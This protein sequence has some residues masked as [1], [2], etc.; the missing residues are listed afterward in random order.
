VGSGEPG[1]LGIRR[2]AGSVPA[3]LLGDLAQ[4]GVALWCILPDSERAA[5]LHSDLQQVLR[6]DSSVLFLPPTD[7]RPY[8]P[9]H[10]DDPAPVIQRADVFQRLADGWRGVLVTGADALL[11]KVPALRDVTSATLTVSVGPSPGP[12][13]LLARL[14]ELGFARVEFVEQPGE[15]ALRGGILDVFPFVGDFP[16]RLEFFGDDIDSIREF[17]IHTQRSVSRR[18]SARLVPNLDRDSAADSARRVSLA[19]CLSDDIVVALFDPDS[20]TAELR[21]RFERISEAFEARRATGSDVRPPGDWYLH[22]EALEAGIAARRRLVLGGVGAPAAEREIDFAC[23]P[24]PS[25]NRAMAPLR[26]QLAVNARN[27]LRTV[28]LCDSRGQENRLRQLLEDEIEPLGVL[29]TVESLHEGFEAPGLGLAV[30]TDHQIFERY[31]RP[32]ARRQKQRFGGLSLRELHQLEPGDFVVHVDYG[33]GRFAGMDRIEVQGRMQEVV[34]LLYRSDDVLYVNVG[35]LH[36]LHK[37]KGKE[38]HQPE[39][40]KL[41]SGQWERTKSRTKKRVKDIARDLIQLYARRKRSEGY[42]FADDSVWQRELEA[43]F[44]FE[45]TP[46]QAAASDAVKTDMEQP[47]PMDRLV[48]G[49][50]GFGKTEIAVRAA[51]KA[52]QDGRQVAVLVPTTV[53]ASQHL[54]TFT[55]RLDRFPVRVEM[56]SRFR[57]GA[58]SRRVVGGLADGTVDVVIGTHRL[59]SSDVRFKSLGLLIV[60]EEQRFGV[61]VKEKLR[62]LRVDVDTLTLTATPIPRTLQFSLLGARDLSIISTPPPNRQPIVTEIHTFDKDLVRDAILYEVHRGG[63]VFFI[64]N[65][66]QSIQDVASMVRSILPDVRIVVAH[67]QMKGSDLERVMLQFVERKADVLVSTSIIENGLDIANANTIIIDRA[68]HFGLS[69]LHQLRGRVG[70]SDRKAF[71]YLLVPSTQGLTREAK[72]RLQAVE[73]F[74]ELGSGFQIAMRDLDIRGAGNLLGAEQSGFIE[75]VGFET[76]HRILDEAVAELR[77]DEFSDLFDVRSIPRPGDTAVEIDEDALIPD[78]YVANRIERLNLYRRLSE[79]SSSDALASV[80]DEMID[81]FGPLPA[82]VTSLLRATELR[83]GAQAL[84]LS[85]VAHRN[86]RLF[87]HFPDPSDDPYFFESVFHPLLARLAD[88]DRRYVLKESKSG[89]LRAIVQDVSD[90]GLALDILGRLQA[91]SVP[92]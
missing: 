23:R 13:P 37:Y 49:D 38:G 40:T 11:E 62:K 82:E 59:I 85:K 87:L 67:G 56:L 3:F 2:A 50:V 72:Q 24:Q 66:I 46:D 78:R 36:K 4:R 88:L 65:R 64:H 83:I 33:I 54:K 10:V 28:I 16:V 52:V 15:M 26:R 43:S 44:A 63:Q 79:A 41:G 21:T 18:T 22:P 45:D 68:D 76:Y 60:D 75:D 77:T 55:R 47:V 7:H 91:E 53:L 51:F 12:A 6:D 69:E 90:L 32:T 92:A 14:S 29:L 57:T 81:R 58:D 61:G 86:D 84:R 89:R 70:R 42:A 71:C 48:C 27:G 35:A 30:Y 80:R 73:E 9:D 31:H 17:D 5:Y 25:F 34:R 1:E 39:L 20:V 19:D 8:D 74:S